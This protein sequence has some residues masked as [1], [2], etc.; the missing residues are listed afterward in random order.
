MG[1]QPTALVLDDLLTRLD[2]LGRIQRLLLCPPPCGTMELGLTVRTLCEAITEARFDPELS[3]VAL[4]IPEDP[5][6]LDSPRAWRILLIVTELLTNVARH[7]M[8][9]GAV[10]A[11]VSL[12][13]NSFQIVCVVRDDGVADRLVEPGYGSRVVSALVAELAGYLEVDCCSAGT[14]VRLI[15]PRYGANSARRPPKDRR[16]TGCDP[17]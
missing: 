1:D 7:G 16:R 13:A 11:R 12:T 8:R 2:A 5:I 14:E 4:D 3:A 9:S 10:Q 6:V 17:R 15:V